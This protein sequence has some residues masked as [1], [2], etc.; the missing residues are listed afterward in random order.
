MTLT[1]RLLATIIGGLLVWLITIVISHFVKRGRLRAALLADIAIHV[2]GA[3]EQCAA[4]AKLVE[5]HVVEGN[6]FPYPI[7]YVV[8][9]Y[10]LYKSLQ[11]NMSD[12]LSKIELVKVVKF[13]QALWEMDISINGLTATLGQLERDRTVITRELI[14]HIRRRKDRI[15]SYCLVLGGKDIGKLK[16]LPDDYKSIKGPA[17]VIAK[18]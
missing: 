1:D 12:Y 14:A 6:R 10:L 8:G 16:D 3:K 13:Y 17:T 5:D 11:Q 9:E 18:T 2:A 7:S 15:D 4:V